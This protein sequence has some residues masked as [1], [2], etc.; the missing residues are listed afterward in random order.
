MKISSK[1]LKVEKI[2]TEVIQRKTNATCSSYL[3]PNVKSLIF[4]VQPVIVVKARK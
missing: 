1:L 3:V 2:S 4:S